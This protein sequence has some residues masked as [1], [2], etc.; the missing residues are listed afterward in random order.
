MILPLLDTYLPF[1]VQDYLAG[2][3]IALFSFSFFQLQNIG[4][5]KFVLDVFA[6]PQPNSYLY[7]IG[8][9]SASTFINVINIL[10]MLIIILS[11]HSIAIVVKL[12]LKRKEYG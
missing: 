5:V 11:L 1:I 8:L 3:D 4:T 6:Y 10:P 9:T 7:K 12:C 2:L